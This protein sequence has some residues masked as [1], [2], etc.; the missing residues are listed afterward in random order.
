MANLAQI[1]TPQIIA[2]T[3]FSAKIVLKRVLIVLF[4][5]QCFVKS[6]LGPQIVT[7]QKAKL[8]PDI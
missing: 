1:I 8:G 5:K 4:D 6:K 3:S 2:R 7:P